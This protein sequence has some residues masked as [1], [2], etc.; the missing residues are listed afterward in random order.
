M[1]SLLVQRIL[2]GILILSS[3][4]FFFLISPELNTNLRSEKDNLFSEDT[5]ISVHAQPTLPT[6]ERHRKIK[7]RDNVKCS[8]ALFGVSEAEE[9][10]YFFSSYTYPN[11]SEASPGLLTVESD[12]IVF[13]CPSNGIFVYGDILSEEIY[14]RYDKKI[15]WSTKKA[16]KYH[17]DTEWIFGKCSD[18]RLGYLRNIFN[19]KAAQRS[20]ALTKVLSERKSP[21][22]PL[23]VLLIILDSVSRQSF[24]R[25]LK[26]TVSFLNSQVLDPASDLGKS[27]LMYDFLINNAQGEKTP[28]NMGPILYGKDIQYLEDSLINYSIFDESD[29]WAFEELQNS[30]AIW[31]HYENQGFVTMFSYDSYTD[32]LSRITGRRIFTDHVVSNFWRAANEIT[33]YV[34]FGDEGQCIGNR[35]AHKFSFDYLGQYIRNYQGINRFAYMH[36]DVAHESTGLRAKI[37]DSDVA[38]FIKDTLEFYKQHPE[39]DVVLFIAAD[40]GRMSSMMSKEALLEKMLPFHLVFAN[41]ELIERMGAHENLV[42][43]SERLVTRFDWHVTLKELA[44]APYKQLSTEQL[45]KL[46]DGTGDHRGI[47]LFSQQVPDERN[48]LSVRIPGEYCSC[49]YNENIVKNPEND[50]IIQQI[51]VKSVEAI[52]G[53][54]TNFDPSG[55]CR[56]ITLGEIISAREVYVT[57]KDPLE[58]KNY[59]INIS[60]KSNPR[61]ILTIQARYGPRN[62]FKP[63]TN[64]YGLRPMFEIPVIDQ[65]DRVKTLEVQIF[66]MQIEDPLYSCTKISKRLNK[67]ENTC[68]CPTDS[69]ESIRLFHNNNLGMSCAQ[70]CNKIDA[71]CKEY[72]YINANQSSI[73]DILTR[74]N[75]NITSTAPGK[76]FALQNSVL[77]TPSSDYCDLTTNSTTLCICYI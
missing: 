45:E 71:K 48:C 49:Y 73:I 11:C 72:E 10:R 51:A 24:F 38:E 52:N 16:F 62:D 33:G 35:L 7:S 13:S 50:E 23:S 1:N 6:L 22:R 5:T 69:E 53:F 60:E 30:S 31:K 61:Y 43:N 64:K 27:F 70:F 37:A 40:H 75:F 19:Q 36:I 32:Y 68:N 15:K 74:N 14:G 21:P 56:N 66:T 25:N 18:L 29:W 47:S 8:P 28:Q 3:C 44:F 12:Q 4:L 2:I 57:F 17:L 54:F 77:I 42:H 20:I 9:S 76:I 65:R 46:G 39:E 34:D 41:R 26:E 55:Y 59:F 67:F 58:L 63:L